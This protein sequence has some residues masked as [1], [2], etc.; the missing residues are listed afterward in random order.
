MKPQKFV[1]KTRASVGKY[2][3]I[4][5]APLEAGDMVKVQDT[6]TDDLHTFQILEVT[7][8]PNNVKAVAASLIDSTNPE[9]KIGSRVNLTFDPTQYIAGIVIKKS[10]VM[11]RMDALQINDLMVVE[12]YKWLMSLPEYNYRR[13]Y[14]D[15]VK[16]LVELQLL[17]D[18]DDYSLQQKRLNTAMKTRAEYF[19]STGSYITATG[20]EMK[21]TSVKMSQGMGASQVK[22]LKLTK[23]VTGIRLIIESGF[24]GDFIIEE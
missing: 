13:S 5:G 2:T 17:P 12:L 14:K 4:S 3:D 22:R 18:T 8:R 24:L 19:K 7:E 1:P 21:E 16:Y 6:S 23:L 11:S 15:C 9:Y 10:E 20:I